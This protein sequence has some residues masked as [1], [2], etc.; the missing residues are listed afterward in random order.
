MR[1]SHTEDY[2]GFGYETNFSSVHK[3]VS[4]FFFFL[5]C[6]IEPSTLLCILTVQKQFRKLL[7]K[8]YTDMQLRCM[9]AIYIHVTRAYN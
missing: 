8:D 6:A 9:F 1:K 4:F 7:Y 5:I 3:D 2:G